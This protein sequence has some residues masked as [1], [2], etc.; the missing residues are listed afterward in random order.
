MTTIKTG[1]TLDQDILKKLGKLMQLFNYRSR[2]KVIN[3]ALELYISER[4]LLMNKG[5]AT[6]IVLIVYN[7]HKKN[8]EYTLTHIQHE[9]LNTIVGTF[10]LHLDER[11]CMEA[12]IVKGEIED[13]RN[14]VSELEGTRNLRMLRHL[15]FHINNQ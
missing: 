13:I 10:H 4:S 6:G 15:L 14:L 11:N 3:E 8:I 5:K 2:S 1:V 12:I 7:H 9:Y